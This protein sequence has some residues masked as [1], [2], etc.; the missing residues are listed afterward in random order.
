MAAR[1][2]P[3][4][5]Q[6]LAACQGAP[7]I[8]A[9]GLPRLPPCLVPCVEP[10]G[11]QALEPHAH[12]SLCGLRSDVDRKKIAALAY[13]CGPDRLP[14]PRF[15]G[16]APWDEV[17][18]RQALTRQVAEHVGPAEGVLGCEPSGFPQAGPASVGVARQWCG[19][20]G[21]VAH[22]P[23]AV[24]WGS[25]SG[26]GHPLVAM[27]LSLPN[28][29]TRD[30][31]RLDNAGVPHAQ[32]GYRS[33]PPLALAMWQTRGPQRPPGGSAGAAEM[34]RPSG[35]RRRLAHLG[36]RSLLA[37]PGHALLRALE[38][39][40]LAARGRRRPPTLPWQRVEGWSAAL[41]AGA[42]QRSDVRDGSQG[43]LVVERVTGRVVARTP[44]AAPR[45]RGA[46][47][48]P[49]RPRARPPAGG[50]SRWVARPCH[51]W[52]PAGAVGPGSP[53]RPAHRRMPPAQHE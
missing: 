9:Q 35:L 2:A 27:R 34:G 53:S 13:R 46:G 1:Y 52:D 29:W 7:A 11:R 47:S 31:A 44:A 22:W 14:L 3:R 17:A 18:L 10:C 6:W 16:W 51:T 36:E 21:T 25:V 42:W 32:R 24:A 45:R 37:V 50:A 26:A 30:K 15:L 49:P 39:A 5:P 40:P 4:Q 38:P 12:P 41:D 43:P 28:A 20:L 19:R 33:R 23:G 8:V 48:R